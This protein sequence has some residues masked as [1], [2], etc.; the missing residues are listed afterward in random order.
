MGMRYLVALPSIHDILF[1]E[2][3]LKKQ[4]IAFDIVPTP[5]SIS[6][7]CGMVIEAS[8]DALAAIRS[9]LAAHRIKEEGCWEVE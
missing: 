6:T 5:T 4:A 2:A 7:D 3:E 1:V 9:V 8:A